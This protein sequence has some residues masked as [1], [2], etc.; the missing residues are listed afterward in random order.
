MK[1]LLITILLMQAPVS[2]WAAGSGLPLLDVDLAHDKATLKQ[3][4]E[5]A[6][7]VCT[8]CHSF[9]YIKYRD[10]LAIGFSEQEV[11]GLRGDQELTASIVSLSPADMMVDSYGLVPPDLSIIAKARKG[12][13]RYVYTLFNSFYVRDDGNVDNHLFPGIRMPDVLGV[14]SLDGEAKKDTQESLKKVASFLEWASDPN[15]EERRSLGVYVLVYLF[16]FTFM[17]WLMKRRVWAD[18]H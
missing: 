13:G 11:D 5:F 8:G 12:G 3:G 10:L 7:S 4:A 16:I 14:A 1:K 9:K 15:G 18:V 2:V 17:L 6:L